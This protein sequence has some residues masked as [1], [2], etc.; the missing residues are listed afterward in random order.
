MLDERRTAIAAAVR[1]I[2]PASLDPQRLDFSSPEPE[3]GMTGQVVIPFFGPP[4]TLSDV[5]VSISI[6]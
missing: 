2:D 3:A 6:R 5:P 4:V 1:G